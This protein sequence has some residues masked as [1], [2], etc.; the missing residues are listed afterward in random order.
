MLKSLSLSVLVFILLSIHH[1]K[2]ANYYINSNIGK[3]SNQGT[4]MDSPWKGF[5]NLEKNRYLPGDSILFASGTS[6]KGGFIFLSSGT[7]EKHI[8]FSCYSL[9]PD[10]IRTIPRNE[11]DSLFVRYGGGPAPAF[12]NP[13]WTILSGNIFHIKGSYVTISGLY[14]FDNAYPPVLTI[15]IKTFRKWELFILPLDQITM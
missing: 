15:K 9:H 3:D 14:F 11:L 7:P 6:Y 4:S 5:A 13:D 1:T 2:A 12:T 8:V 10:S